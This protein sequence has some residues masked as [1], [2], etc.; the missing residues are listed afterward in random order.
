MSPLT[1]DSLLTVSMSLARLVYQRFGDPTNTDNGNVHLLVSTA[2]FR[3]NRFAG[4]LIRAASDRYVM[5]S[6]TLMVRTVS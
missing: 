4:I 1:D 3:E 5:E 6:S 2:Y